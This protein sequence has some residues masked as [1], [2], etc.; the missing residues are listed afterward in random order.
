MWKEALKPRLAEVRHDLLEQPFNERM[1]TLVQLAE[2]A[3]VVVSPDRTA[4][5][6]RGMQAYMPRCFDMEGILM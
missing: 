1:A 4:A 3:T 6:L 2:Q 5:A